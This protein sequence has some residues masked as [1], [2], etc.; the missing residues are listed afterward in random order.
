M[1]SAIYPVDYLA[2][3]RTSGEKKHSALF[4]SP[5]TS[6]GRAPLSKRHFHLTKYINFRFHSVYW[7]HRHLLNRK[8]EDW[9]MGRSP[10]WRRKNVYIII[11]NDPIHHHHTH[12]RIV[13]TI[14]ASGGMRENRID[15]PRRTKT[16][17][18][19][20]GKSREREG[21]I[22]VHYLFN[23]FLVYFRSEERRV[24]EHYWIRTLLALR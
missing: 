5:H 12:A 2:H 19:F 14:G 16:I 23:P 1:T 20:H 7:C 11:I 4:C 21:P 15:F 10:L 22:R 3:Q 6:A 13:I 9:T 17:R 18:N 24:T 8:D